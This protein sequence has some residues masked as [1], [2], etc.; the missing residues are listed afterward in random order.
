MYICRV[1]N[2]PTNSVHSSSKKGKT[3]MNQLNYKTYLLT[4]IK[5]LPHTQP[6]TKEAIN[7]QESCNSPT[8]EHRIKRSGLCLSAVRDIT[9][10]RLRTSCFEKQSEAGATK[11]CS[12]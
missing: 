9:Y 8:V 4:K 2:N 5:M 6:L 3:H 1:S 7:E 11:Q 10:M 12:E